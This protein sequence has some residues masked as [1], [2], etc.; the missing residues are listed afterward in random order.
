MYWA[1]NLL[2]QQGEAWLEIVMAKNEHGLVISSIQQAIPHGQIDN[3]PINW[4]VLAPASDPFENILV[5]TY[6]LYG[7]PNYTGGVVFGTSFALPGI[8]LLDEAYRQHDLAYSNA[9]TLQDRATADLVLLDTISLIPDTQ[10]SPEGH[11]YAAA[12][13]FVVLAQLTQEAQ[14]GLL[15]LEQ[16][17]CLAEHTPDYIANASTNLG[18]A[19][20]EPA[21]NERGDLVKWLNTAL[22]A[23][24]ALDPNLV[25]L[26]VDTLTNGAASSSHDAFDFTAIA[27]AAPPLAHDQVSLQAAPSFELPQVTLEHLPHLVAE[28]P[29]VTHGHIPDWLL[30]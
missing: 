4:S 22:D 25:T 24:S 11:L 1:G 28:V 9:L 13:T 12:T 21:P 20:L 14:G 18:D 10:L 27:P 26:V 16:T 3:G 19:G 6:G 29:E 17:F 23:V 2:F 7:G 8:N 15:T 30:A 5:P